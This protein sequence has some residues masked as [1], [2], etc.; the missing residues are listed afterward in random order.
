M[1]SRFRRRR[2]RMQS[3]FGFATTLPGLAPE[4]IFN[5]LIILT[6]PA[7]CLTL[8]GDTAV[9]ESRTSVARVVLII[10]VPRTLFMR[11]T[12]PPRERDTKS[13]DGGRLF[14]CSLTHFCSARFSIFT[15]K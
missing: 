4:N 11:V 6:S 3:R 12:G 13:Q 10:H 14:T 2:S 8:A 15:V 5:P 1:C 7:A 9:V